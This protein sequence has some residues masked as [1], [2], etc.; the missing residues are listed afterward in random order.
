VR[1]RPFAVVFGGAGRERAT[2]EIAHLRDEIEL[3]LFH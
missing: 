2:G 3:T 1:E